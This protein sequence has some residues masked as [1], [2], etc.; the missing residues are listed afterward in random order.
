MHALKHENDLEMP[1]KKKLSAQIVAD[2]AKWIQM[3]AP[4]P[5][6][7]KHVELAKPTIDFEKAR[8]FWSFQPLQ[9]GKLPQPQSKDWSRNDVD[10]YVAFAQE[11]RGIKPVAPASR[12]ILIRRLYYGL[13]GLPPTQT[14]VE[15]FQNDKSADAYNK[16]VDSLLK[17]EHYGERWARHWLDLARFAESNGYAFD[18]DRAAAFHYR[19]FVIKALNSD[20]PYD[21]FTRLQIAGDLLRPNDYMGIS[22]TGFLVAGPFTT[23]QTAKERERSRYEQLDDMIGTLGTTMLGLTIGCARCH[24]HKYDPLPSQDYYRMISSF[25]EVG[26]QDFG[27]DEHPEVY[28]KEK[29]DFDKLHQPLVTARA[30]YEKEKLPTLLANWIKNRPATAEPPTMSPWQWIGP[31]TA[32][33]FNK[34]YDQNFGPE[35]ARRSQKGSGQAQVAGKAGVERWCGP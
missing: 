4:D 33:D 3:G 24:D 2:F 20:M 14:Q 15:D 8:Q 27:L 6:D 10:R 9:P 7:G 30:T 34:A 32:A 25:A 31:F 13:L 28:R 12:Q 1:P 21:E 18:K 22:A 11:E 17:S 19:D 23:Q 26:F 29:A 16:L 35:K 5:R